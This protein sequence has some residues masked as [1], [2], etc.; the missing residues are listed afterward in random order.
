[1]TRARK[2]RH[3][4]THNDCEPDGFLIRNYRE[5]EMALVCNPKRLALQA[6]TGTLAVGTVQHLEI[7]D[8]TKVLGIHKVALH[9]FSMG[10]PTDE[11]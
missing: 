9:D 3:F 11:I 5:P 4:P 6:A 8:V 7:I 10:G 2:Q 1:M